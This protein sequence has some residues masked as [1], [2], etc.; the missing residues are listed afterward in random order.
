[1]EVLNHALVQVLSRDKLG[2]NATHK[3]AVFVCGEGFNNVHLLLVMMEDDF[4]S[5]GSVIDFETFQSPQGLNNVCN[6]QVLDEMS[7]SDENVWFLSLSKQMLMQHMMRDAKVTAVATTASDTT[8]GTLLGQSNL[9]KAKL[10]TARQSSLAMKND[11]MHTKTRA[12]TTEGRN[13]RTT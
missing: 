2:T 3:F 13:K 10:E 11:K 12:R 6:K 9:N 8:P 7:K 1:M 5:V 4:K